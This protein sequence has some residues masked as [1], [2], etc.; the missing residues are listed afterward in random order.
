MKLIAVA[1]GTHQGAVI[2]ALEHAY[3]FKPIRVN[4]CTEVVFD[5][6]RVI[7]D[8]ETQEQA[9]QVCAAGGSVWHMQP[10]P[11]PLLLGRLDHNIQATGTARDILN[12]VAG[13]LYRTAD[14]PR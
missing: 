8:L 7:T 6:N 2:A 3:K 12:V 5:T 13:K 9:D 1:P 10:T 11:T 4:E 14:L